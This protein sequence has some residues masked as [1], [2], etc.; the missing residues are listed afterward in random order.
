MSDIYLRDNVGYDPDDLLLYPSQ[1]LGGPST[2]LGSTT[3]NAQLAVVSQ[4]KV[5]LLAQTTQATVFAQSAAPRS[6][7]SGELNA[8]VR[9]T[10]DEVGC[11]K[12]HL[13]ASDM[14][15]FTTATTPINA[16]VA[17]SALTLVENVLA[18]GLN[19]AVW[20]GSTTQ[21][22][23]VVQSA[24][25]K[26]A[27][28]GQS[29]QL[30]AFTQSSAGELRVFG[31]TSHYFNFQQSA[32]ERL[33]HRVSTAPLIRLLTTAKD[34]GA[35]LASAT[36][37][38]ALSASA[39]GTPAKVGLSTPLVILAQTSDGTRG[40][41][42]LSNALCAFQTLSSPLGATTGSI[43]L[44]TQLGAIG[45][46]F[47]ITRGDAE[48]EWRL[49]QVSS[50]DL[51][52]LRASEFGR[53]VEVIR[54]LHLGLTGERIGDTLLASPLQPPVEILTPLRSEPQA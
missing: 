36:Y 26:A 16:V 7:T 37:A 9:F 25:G 14:L 52:Y 21:S 24:D 2:H 31:G 8:F 51:A 19:F 29:T 28:L 15:R 22:Q 6:D 23:Q 33:V 45:D 48:V 17:G 32:A 38:V 40:V 47:C 34:D 3:Q 10:T 5:Q 53:E 1:V 13:S 54:A 49:V 20:T 43:A 46:P 44:L 35:I 42:S 39:N 11:L 50:S 18:S 4:S 27:R 30:V 41:V 12:V